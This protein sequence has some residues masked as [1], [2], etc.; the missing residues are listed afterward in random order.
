MGLYALKLGLNFELDDVTN[1][2]MFHFVTVLKEDGAGRI[3]MENRGKV[4]LPHLAQRSDT[5]AYVRGV[6]PKGLDESPEFGRSDGA[7][8]KVL[9]CH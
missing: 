8:G 5:N 6:L 3:K 1:G 2:E 9:L 4:F 7:A